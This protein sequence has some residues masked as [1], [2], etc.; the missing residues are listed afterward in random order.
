MLTDTPR[1]Q[2][3]DQEA[4][5]AILG[6]VLLDAAAL[7]R[8]QEFVTA[9]EFYNTQHQRIYQAMTDLITSGSILDVLT[10]GDLL[11]QQGHLIGIGGRGALAEFLTIVA[12]PANVVQHAQIVH[13]HAVR[14]KLIKLAAT[15]SQH[16][17]ER[18][19]PDEILHELEQGLS[20]LTSDRNA[21]TWCP[22]SELAQETVE[23]VD[24]ASKRGAELIGIPTGFRK[25]NELFGGWQRSDLIILAAR[26][27]MGKT[28]LALGAAIAAAEHG[29][30]VG[31][32]SLEMSRQQLG[33]RIHGMKG[34]LDVHALRT[35]R[36]FHEGW[37]QLA[38]VAEQVG[39][40]PLWVDDS[41]LVTVEQL[42]AKAKLLQ[43]RQ[44][45]DLLIVDYLQLL[46]MPSREGHQ[47]AVAHASRRLKLLA[48]ELD[49]PVIVLSQLSRECERREKKQPVLADLRDSGA[50]EQDAD[51][52]MFIYRHEVYVPDTD[53][54]GV[55]ELLVR[56]HRNGP[57]GD[58]RLKFVDR[59]ARFEDLDD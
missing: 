21:R 57:I 8:A 27:S 39:K 25:L 24:Q 3:H 17:Y 36:L 7:T 38:H 33:Q 42:C 12:S 30:K 51:V 10:V 2:P 15:V 13:N 47:L 34:N 28:S 5:Q 18:A 58:R 52:V 48:K 16:A 20:T 45:L 6:A 19:E 59:Y 40:L 44:G 9:G 56:K 43:A 14:R 53:E 54:K 55:A 46:H 1:L 31:I 26:P 11:E 32:V 37:W 49:I 41:P 50:I 23:Y 4:E 22:A 35:G 29:F